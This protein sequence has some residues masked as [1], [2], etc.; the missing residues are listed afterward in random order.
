MESQTSPSPEPASHVPCGLSSLARVQRPS[1]DLEVCK[2]D[3]VTGAQ[4]ND[5]P[6]SQ[7][8]CSQSPYA[9]TPSDELIGVITST[10][11]PLKL[12]CAE[13]RRRKRACDKKLPCSLCKEKGIPCLYRSHHKNR[14]TISS[15]QGGVG[16]N[17]QRLE[18]IIDAQGKRITQLERGNV[19]P[20]PAASREPS[21]PDDLVP[22]GREC[23]LDSTASHKLIGLWPS[24]KAL[25]RAAGVNV[26]DGY[27]AD[28]E[29]VSKPPVYGIAGDGDLPSATHGRGRG[30]G[31]QYFEDVIG[32]HSPRSH[33]SSARKLDVEDRLE[34]SAATINH[35]FSIYMERIYIMHPFL[36]AEEL[37]KSLENF[38]A[39]YDPGSQPF[40]FSGVHDESNRQRKRQRPNDGF[41]VPRERSPGDAIFFL[42]LALGEVCAHKGPLPATELDPDS[43][44]AHTFAV[45][46]LAYYERAVDFME[47]DVFSDDLI[48]AQMFLLAGLYKEQLARVKESMSWFSKAGTLLWKLIVHHKLCNDNHWTVHGDLRRQQLDDN[49]PMVTDK[50]Q[51]LVAVAACSCM[52]LESDILSELHLPSSGIWKMGD[53]LPLPRSLSREAYH[54]ELLLIYTSQAF[55]RKRLNQAHSE[56][57]GHACLAHSREYI[58]RVLR[59]HGMILDEWKQ[60]LPPTM[61]WGDD[62]PP[63][64]RI[65]LARLQAKYWESMYVTNRPF[66]DYALHIMPHVQKGR[67]VKDIALDVHGN[68]RGEAEIRVLDAIGRMG[69]AEVLTASKRCVEAAIRSTVAFDNILGRLIVTNIHGTA[70]A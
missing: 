43:D 70:H 10:G 30:R 13:C 9:Q 24:T 20:T 65:L 8:S 39:R 21:E 61:K 17:S 46:G 5:S 1:S 15:F 51:H 34:L 42:V 60:G 66:L 41:E 19:M 68:P 22:F 14:D 29:G 37:R 69:D 27:V 50:L 26:E 47:R 40:Y 23:G 63:S 55:L 4:L 64:S 62:D 2:E 59:C 45:P 53:R 35:H 57:Y 33:E 18:H 44:M 52:Q 67:S 28:A 54:E 3:G 48:H 31:F 12:A 6:H 56:L 38:T 32:S 36:D 58:S 25:L 11:N 49:R 16:T 7:P